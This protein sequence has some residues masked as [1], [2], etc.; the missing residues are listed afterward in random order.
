VSEIV[1]IEIECT[2]CGGTG[3]YHGF[4]EPPGV[5]VICLGCNGTG[6]EKLKYTPFTGRKVRKGIKTVQRSRGNFIPTG[7]GPAG[8]SITYEQFL[9]GKM[10]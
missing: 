7:I 4:A 9:K 3:I 6:K 8:R 1:T 10:P 2:A 5:G